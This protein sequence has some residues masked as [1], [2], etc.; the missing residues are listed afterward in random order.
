MPPGWKFI[1]Q[2]IYPIKL[3]I[4]FIPNRRTQKSGKNNKQIALINRLKYS[5]IKLKFA[6]RE[7]A[8]WNV[9]WRYHG[10]G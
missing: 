1:S 4:K 2:L 9:T 6:V 7:Y 5:V 8:T 10:K 3:D